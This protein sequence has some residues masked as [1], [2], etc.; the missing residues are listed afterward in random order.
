MAKA[1]VK[2]NSHQNIMKLNVRLSKQMQTAS[3]V[4]QVEGMTMA[5]LMC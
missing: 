4:R 3:K 2:V 1:S 5:F